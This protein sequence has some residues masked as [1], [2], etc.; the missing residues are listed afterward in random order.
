MKKD[1]LLINAPSAFDS[2]SGTRVNAVVQNF[3]LLSMAYLSAVARKEGF[4]VFVLD[5]G[6]EADPYKTLHKAL[7]LFQP[8]FV[9]ITSTTPIFPEVAGL[10]RIV[11]DRMGNRTKLILGGPH[12]TALPVESLKKSH[13]DILV[14]GEGEETLVEILQEK[15]LNTIKGIYYKKDGQVFKTEPRILT[16][17]LD[18]L[19]LP[20]IDLFDLKRYTFPKLLYRNSPTIH[21]M[22]SRGC[23]YGCTFCNKNI[24]GRRF[25][26]KSP[27]LVVEEID[28]LLRSGIKEIRITDD[29][30]TTDMERAKTI[31]RLIIKKRL[32]FPWNLGAGLRVDSVDEEFLRLAKESGLYQ[33]SLAF[34]SGDQ[35]SLDSINKGIT[36]EQSIRAMKM[37]KKVGLE[38]VGFFMFGLPADTEESLKKT[39]KFAT[40][41]RPDMAKVTITNPF[42]GTELYRQYE[43]KGLIKS[44]DWTL[45]NLHNPGEIYQH[46][47]LSFETMRKYYNNFYFKFYFNPRYILQ[48]LRL[49]FKNKTLLTDIYYGFQTFFPNV[50]RTKPPVS[51]LDFKK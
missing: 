23:V 8:R 42:P 40:E 34:E 45:Y 29:M 50:L 26:G 7:E 31:C 38:S 30:F 11:K 10:S 28:Y 1:L 39:T 33:V 17:N 20:A 27:E 24:F 32:K 12:G 22:T 36:I 16:G 43:E 21:Y 49:S 18:S 41:L 37:V 51:D 2:Y 14:F 46:P 47:N 3:P 13:F 6:I 25:R 44:K 19:P 5:L 48:R 4:S 9:G 15:P 35:K